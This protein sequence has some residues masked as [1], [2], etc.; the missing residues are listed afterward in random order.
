LDLAAAN[1]QYLIKFRAAEMNSV[2]EPSI[3]EE[4]IERAIRFYRA[5]ICYDNS[6]LFETLMKVRN[7]TSIF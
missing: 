2:L 6:S 1:I 3:V 7:C 4:I 5:D